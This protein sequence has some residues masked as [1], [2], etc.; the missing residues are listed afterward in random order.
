MPSPFPGMDPYLE[1]S[2]LFGTLHDSLIFTLMAQLQANLP[3]PYFASITERIWVD[4]S[5]RHVK[6]DINI[7]QPTPPD[8]D[9]GG[10]ALLT[11]AVTLLAE[12]ATK[13]VLVEATEEHIEQL[14]EIMTL[15]GETERLITTIEILSPDNKR[16]G[17]EGRRKYLAKQ[18]EVLAAGI[19][20]VEIDLLRSGS[21]TTA[22]PAS[23]VREQAGNFHYHACVTR[24]GRRNCQEVYPIRLRER[25]PTLS[26]PLLPGVRDV[27]LDLQAAFDRSYDSGPYRR[28]V[29]YRTTMPQPPL[30]PEDAAWVAERLDAT[31]TQ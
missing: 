9:A 24:G 26:I 16:G 18:D 2:L 13:P 30:L 17:G 10:V 4:I 6:P 1:S 8:S 22:V 7:L 14:V 28:R 3:A 23:W 19:S 20:L 25:L 11:S 12:S 29:R 31:Q 21:H 15:E 5:D 27:A